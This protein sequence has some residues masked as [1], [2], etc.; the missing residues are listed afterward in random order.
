MAVIEKLNFVH[1]EVSINIL[2]ADV[3]DLGGH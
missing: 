3:R 1:Y 2:G